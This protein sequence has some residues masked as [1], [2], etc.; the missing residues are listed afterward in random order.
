MNLISSF[1]EAVISKLYEGRI[2]EITLGTIK[3]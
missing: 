3:Y 1:N 2:V